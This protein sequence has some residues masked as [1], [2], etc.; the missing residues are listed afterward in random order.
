M[1]R[2]S[3]RIRWEALCDDTEIRTEPPAYDDPDD[4]RAGLRQAAMDYRLE[5]VCETA[6]MVLLVAVADSC[7]VPVGSGSAFNGLP[8]NRGC[9][10][11]GTGAVRCGCPVSDWNPRGVHLFSALDEDVTAFDAAGERRSSSSAWR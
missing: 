8:A 10:R 2:R 3:G 4:S 1:A 6:G 9:V 11:L 7:G 5:I